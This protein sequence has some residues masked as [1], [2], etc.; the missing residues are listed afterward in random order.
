MRAGA[1]QELN[2]Q[3]RPGETIYKGHR[4]YDLMRNLQLGIIF[5]IARS[6]KEASD[7]LYDGPAKEEEFAQQVCCSL[8]V[9]SIFTVFHH[10]DAYLLVSEPCTKSKTWSV[11]CQAL[12]L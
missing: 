2:K 11:C 6:T 9:T 4:S 10:Q 8:N 7:G 3:A 12:Q 5:S 1:L